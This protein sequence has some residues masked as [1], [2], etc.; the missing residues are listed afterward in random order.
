MEVT[1]RFDERIN[2]K[3]ERKVILGI[4]FIIENKIIY[5]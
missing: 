1:E 2:V 4:D 5:F 3:D